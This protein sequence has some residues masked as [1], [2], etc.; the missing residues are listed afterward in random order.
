MNTATMTNAELR[1]LEA[2]RT[3]PPDV[4]R[5]IVAEIA[6]REAGMGRGAAYTAT[7]GSPARVVVSGLD[8]PFW[9]LV[10]LLVKVALASIPAMLILTVAGALLFA[11]VTAIFSV[12]AHS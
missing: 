6:R 10:R 9:D 4:W 2:D 8:L 7:S 3:T 1:R 11:F 5:T 12:V